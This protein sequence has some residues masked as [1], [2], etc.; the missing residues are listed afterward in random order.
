MIYVFALEGWF[1]VFTDCSSSSFITLSSA[2]L[3]FWF[4]LVGFVFELSNFFFIGHACI[5]A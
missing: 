3:L 2:F 4:S 5:L 1:S